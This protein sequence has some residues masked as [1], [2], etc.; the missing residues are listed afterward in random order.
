MPIAVSYI[1]LIL[2]RISHVTRSSLLSPCRDKTRRLLLHS[3][4]KSR[5]LSGPHS[6]SKSAVRSLRTQVLAACYVCPLMLSVWSRHD[7]I[8]GDRRSSGR[9]AYHENACITQLHAIAT[10]FQRGLSRG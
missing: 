3:E 1:A 10:V 4:V 8:F 2:S 5:T 9:Y 7:L 6:P